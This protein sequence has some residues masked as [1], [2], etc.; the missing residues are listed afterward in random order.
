MKD[1]I[2]DLIQSKLKIKEL[3]DKL[4]ILQ[5][6]NDKLLASNNNLI[7]DVDKWKKHITYYLDD[8]RNLYLKSDT[9]KDTNSIIDNSN[10]TITT[11]YDNDNID[12]IKNEV[13]KS[14]NI[15][16]VKEVKEIV[17]DEENGGNKC[18][19]TKKNRNEY[20]REY[21][22]NKRKQQKE[23]IKKIIINKNNK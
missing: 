4:L 20:M 1:I 23:E 3:E 7:K 8:Y 22:R 18:D 6:E 12:D 13:I 2:Y 11:D 10:D 14:D 19:E 17:K 15:E 21:M 5:N 9:V 16:E